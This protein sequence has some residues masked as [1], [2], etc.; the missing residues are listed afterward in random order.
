MLWNL[1]QGRQNAPFDEKLPDQ[2]LVAGIHLRDKTGLVVLKLAELRQVLGVVPQQPDSRQQRGE[3]ERRQRDQR[4]VPPAPGTSRGRLSGRVGKLNWPIYQCHGNDSEGLSAQHT[5][6][7][8]KTQ[9][10]GTL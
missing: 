10:I 6:D 5:V 3:Q 4:D 2:L 9:A 7:S 8:A 1:R